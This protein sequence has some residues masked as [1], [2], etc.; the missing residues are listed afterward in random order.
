VK[1]YDLTRLPIHGGQ[2]L[3]DGDDAPACSPKIYVSNE[4]AS[5]LAAM[6]DLR[7]RAVTVRDRLTSA[8][9]EERVELELE[10]ERMRDQRTELAKRREA[11]FIRKMVMLGHLPPS[12]LED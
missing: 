12:A 11:A 4:E 5:L 9:P 3:P 2:S 8:D 7:V 6:R 10:L 1:E